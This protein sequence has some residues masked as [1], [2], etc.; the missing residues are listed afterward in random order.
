MAGS[1]LRYKAKTE[2][3]LRNFDILPFATKAQETTR[4]FARRYR[5]GKPFDLLIAAHAKAEGA[6]FLTNNF[7]DFVKYKGL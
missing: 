3:V 6:E 2:K 5:A 1:H 4:L 7:K